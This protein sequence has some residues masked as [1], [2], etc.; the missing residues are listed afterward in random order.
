[1]LAYNFNFS[2]V[3]ILLLYVVDIAAFVFL[4]INLWFDANPKFKHVTSSK[5]EAVLEE[6][7]QCACHSSSKFHFTLHEM[8]MV[9][10]RS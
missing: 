5:S 6:Y 3:I 4:Y 7:R 8:A 9:V 10:S 1:L 2:L